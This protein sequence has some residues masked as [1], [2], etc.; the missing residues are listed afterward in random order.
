M[1]I[2]PKAALVL[3]IL[4]LATATHAQNLVQ[5]FSFE[6]GTPNPHWDETSTNFGFVICTDA[7]DVQDGSIP[8]VSGDYA[9]WLGGTDVDE[10]ATVSQDVTLDSDPDTPTWVTFY[11]SRSYGGS[12]MGT[13]TLEVS[14][15]A[16]S[17]FSIPDAAAGEYQRITTSVTGLSGVQ[18]L[19]L[20]ASTTGGTANFL[21]DEVTVEQPFFWDGFES[22]NTS[23]WSTTVP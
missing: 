8:K 21:I 10:T 13:G 22:G 5:D 4:L 7:C 23:V 2:L 20:G 19:F 18:N 9:A 6:L 16:T 17:L 15:G 12:T 11:L 14:L 1:R 3:S